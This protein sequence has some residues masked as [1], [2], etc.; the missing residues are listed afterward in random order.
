MEQMHNRDQELDA[1]FAEYRAA[2]PEAE[3]SATFMP[4]MWGRIEA[5]RNESVFAFRRLAQ[6]WVM[7]AAAV[8][9]LIAIASPMIQADPVIYSASY[10][11]VLDNARSSDMTVAAADGEI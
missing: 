8:V 7:A 3:A 4:G 9:A 10:V 6:I 11:D 5:R 2:F 1:L